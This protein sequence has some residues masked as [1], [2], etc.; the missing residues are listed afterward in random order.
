MAVLLEV[1]KLSKEYY[2]RVSLFK[3]QQFTALSP[4]SFQLHKA[5]T[6]AVIGE[7]GSGK[8][9]LGKL[10]AGAEQPSSGRIRLQGQLLDNNNHKY[11]CSEVR[12]IFQ[13]PKK[14]DFE[15]NPMGSSL[16]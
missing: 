8:S 16:G 2:S 5:E 6:L 11:R 13:D 15:K 1:E 7:S 14:F 3:T 9:T 12:L 10:L 4:I